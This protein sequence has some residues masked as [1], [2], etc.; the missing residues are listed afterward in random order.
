[1]LEQHDKSRFEVFGFDS[2]MDDGSSM[3]RRIDHALDEV[4]G[5]GNLDDASAALRIRDAG[6][7]I[8]VNLNGYFGDQRTGVF[9]R[10]P[11][12]LQVNYLGFPGTMGADYID[13]IVADRT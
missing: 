13:Y 10:K 1:M 11:A 8:L 4:I 6:V 3:R 5:I 9:A 7:D 12:P 2:G